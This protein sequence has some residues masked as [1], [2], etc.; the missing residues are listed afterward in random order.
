MS[1]T[2]VLT[3]LRTRLPLHEEE[4]NATQPNIKEFDSSR[5]SKGPYPAGYANDTF[6]FFG[7]A[8]LL[9]ESDSIRNIVKR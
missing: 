8:A 2:M 6:Y 7:P 9:E 1:T 4:R 3:I 5:S